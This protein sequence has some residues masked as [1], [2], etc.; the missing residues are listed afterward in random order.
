M[1]RLKLINALRLVDHHFAQ[2]Q[3][4]TLCTF[5][6]LFEPI[7]RSSSEHLDYDELYEST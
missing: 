6:G 4:R 7:S 1:K 3:R 5:Q 2:H